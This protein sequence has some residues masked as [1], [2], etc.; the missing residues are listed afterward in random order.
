VILVAHDTIASGFNQDKSLRRG[1]NLDSTSTA[2]QYLSR[3]HQV[4]KANLIP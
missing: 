1:G 4:L 3:F 2:D